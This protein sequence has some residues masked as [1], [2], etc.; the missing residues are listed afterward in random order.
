MTPSI[1]ETLERLQKV[2]GAT[3]GEEDAREKDTQAEENDG[4]AH[5]GNEK[6]TGNNR[7]PSMKAGKQSGEPP[8]SHPKV[9]NPISHGQVIDISRDLKAR[10]I[11]PNNLEALLR[12]SK[13]YTPPPP[14]KPEPVSD[15][16]HTRC[17]KP[18]P[19]LNS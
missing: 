19:Y 18:E 14:P 6:S 16:L 11:Q 10:R 1:V 13:V 2:E 15:I 5:Q 12:G 9:G 4:Q 17:W 8:L 7:D 3:N